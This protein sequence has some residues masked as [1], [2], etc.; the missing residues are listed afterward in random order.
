MNCPICLNKLMKKS[1]TVMGETFKEWYCSYCSETYE[2]VAKSYLDRLD[3]K[4]KKNIKDLKIIESNLNKK[5]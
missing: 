2:L 5:Y 1:R 4:I 3:E